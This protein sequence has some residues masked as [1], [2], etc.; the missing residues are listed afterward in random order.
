MTDNPETGAATPPAATAEAAPARTRPQIKYKGPRR[1]NRP[2]SPRASNAPTREAPQ[3]AEA[4]PD[5][6]RLQRTRKRSEDRF[7]I[8]KRLI[9]NG[10][11]WEYKAEKVLGKTDETHM[12]GL[13]DNHWKEVEQ[14]KHPGVIVRKDGMVLMERPS[15][16]TEDARREDFEEAMTPVRNVQGM[17]SNTPRGTMTRDHPTVRNAS[18]LNRNYDIPIA[19][20][21]PDGSNSEAS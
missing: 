21:S 5:T 15:Y 12:Q 3:R 8:D 18:R 4:R 17:V 13:R 7:F 20:D 9:P 6:G 14:G 1:T 19:G 16:L 11:S 10:W 2:I